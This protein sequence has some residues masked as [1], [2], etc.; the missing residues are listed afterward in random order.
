MTEMS[1]DQ[2]ADRVV[3]SLKDNSAAFRRQRERQFAL[4]DS[5][6]SAK[7]PSSGRGILDLSAA[8]LFRFASRWL[9]ALR[10]WSHF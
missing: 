8:D 2:L 10:N 5:Q 6:R 1:A 4:A 9:Q 7:V 3:R